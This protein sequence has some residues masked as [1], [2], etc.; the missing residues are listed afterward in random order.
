MARP[1]S[2]T[3]PAARGRSA[4]GVRAARGRWRRGRP[5]AAA[6]RAA[7]ASTTPAPLAAACTAAASPSGVSVSLR[8]KPTAPAWM[9]A[10]TLSSVQ[11]EVHTITRAPVASDDRADEVAA[12]RHRRG[13][14]SRG[15]A[16]TARAYS[17][18]SRTDSGVR[19]PRRRRRA[20]RGRP[21]GRAGR[22]YAGRRT[23]S[24]NGALPCPTSA[25]VPRGCRACGLWR[26]YADPRRK[27][28][29]GWP[30]GMR[31]ILTVNRTRAAIPAGTSRDETR[32]D[33]P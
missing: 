17:Q 24:F 16:R 10:S 13:R 32:R 14:A 19:P 7:R 28:R 30:R 4:G 29:R 8:R 31:P 18:A 25:S 21:R 1:R 23:N 2:A 27:E 5:S 15:R 33:G 20:A 6:R 3:A 11:S 9:A 26:Y 22:S 12:A